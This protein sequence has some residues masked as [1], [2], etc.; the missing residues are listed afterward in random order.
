MRTDYHKK[1]K[2][3]NCLQIADNLPQE[4][5]KAI[6]LLIAAFFIFAKVSIISDGSARFL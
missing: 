4:Q 1:Q 3:V 5:A 6:Y 2:A